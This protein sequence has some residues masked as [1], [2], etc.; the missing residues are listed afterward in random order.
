MTGPDQNKIAW[1]KREI[2]YTIEEETGKGRNMHDSRRET[3]LLIP[4]R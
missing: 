1:A 4:I 3:E 2:G